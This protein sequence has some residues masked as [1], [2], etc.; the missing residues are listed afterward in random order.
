MEGL[1]GKEAGIILL[2]QKLNPRVQLPAL[3]RASGRNTM[4]DELEGT[5]CSTAQYSAG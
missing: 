3:E 4:Q 2:R 1:Q 5:Q